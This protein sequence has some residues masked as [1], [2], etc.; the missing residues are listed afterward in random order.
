[1]AGDVARFGFVTLS[2]FSAAEAAERIRS[3]QTGA[4]GGF[5]VAGTPLSV[6]IADL[7]GLCPR[8]RALAIIES[9][10][11]PDYQD[12]VK[13]YLKLSGGRPHG[14]HLERRVRFP[15]KTRADG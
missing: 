7:R 3:G 2:K 5:T 12:E 4:F 13:A 11:H 10:A 1:V 8:D 15:P 9:C 14:P 6:G